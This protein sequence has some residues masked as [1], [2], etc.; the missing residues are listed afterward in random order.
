MI[1]HAACLLSLG[2]LGSEAS[3]CSPQ[4]G[5]PRD[6]CHPPSSLLVAPWKG[7]LQEHPLLLGAQSFPAAL[8]VT[9]PQAPPWA[10]FFGAK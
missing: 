9:A 10:A 6:V 8:E 1:R 2:G 3:G 4:E 7:M 5:G